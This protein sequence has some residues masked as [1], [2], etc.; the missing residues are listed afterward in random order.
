V[1]ASTRGNE[2]LK[3]WPC[4]DLDHDFVTLKCNGFTFDLNYIINQSLVKFPSLVCSILCWQY[5]LRN[6]ARTHEWTHGLTIVKHNQGCICWACWGFTHKHNCWL[7]S[8]SLS[9][10][11]TGQSNPEDADLRAFVHFLIWK[12]AVRLLAQPRGVRILAPVEIWQLQPCT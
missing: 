12:L 7:P 8:R 5:L 10:Y 11:I 1:N 6:A 2:S 3:H 4:R 9:N